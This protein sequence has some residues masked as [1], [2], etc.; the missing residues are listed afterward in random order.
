M[1]RN[2]GRNSGKKKETVKGRRKKRRGR[3][4]G[5]KTMK[6]ETSFVLRPPFTERVFPRVALTVPSYR[7][8]LPSRVSN[9]KISPIIKPWES[10]PNPEARAPDHVKTD[11]TH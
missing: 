6:E 2:P 10:G 4:E 1:S 7:V 9:R 5:K 11:Q 3:K 8:Q